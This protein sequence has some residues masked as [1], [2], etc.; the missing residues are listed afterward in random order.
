MDTELEGRQSGEYVR[1]YFWLNVVGPQY[2][3]VQYHY[4]IARDTS[5]PVAVRVDAVRHMADS[6]R[7][8]IVLVRW[9]LAPASGG[10]GQKDFQGLVDAVEHGFN[11]ALDNAQE[12]AWRES[13]IGGDPIAS[14]ETADEYAALAC[15]ASARKL[16][17]VFDEVVTIASAQG[18]HGPLPV[19]PSKDPLGHESVLRHI[20]EN[21][22][23]EGTE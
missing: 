13:E 17:G 18:L 6:I 23:K 14:P 12:S 8:Y 11:A 7:V 15:H 20:L 3:R 2:G 10:G 1:Y 22:N 5:L 4:E 9:H 19:Q 21:I 16:L